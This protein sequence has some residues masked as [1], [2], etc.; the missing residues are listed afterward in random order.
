MKK[1]TDELT[2]IH[3]ELTKIQKDLEQQISALDSD[4]KAYH[5]Q[6]ISISSQYPEQKEL[7]E[8]IVFVND[9][10]ETRHTQF[11]DIINEALGD[12]V[13]HKKHII[14]LNKKIANN[15]DTINTKKNVIAL[16]LSKVKTISD[17]KTL[18]GIGTLLALI[19]SKIFYEEESLVFLKYLITTLF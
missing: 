12:I 3:T 13:S 16:L 10:L 14:N 7:L 8:F 15:V 5:S 1:V 11:E 4:S 6:I 17:V 9:R 18:L 19:V 2:T